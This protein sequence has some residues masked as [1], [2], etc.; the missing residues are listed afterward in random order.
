MLGQQENNLGMAD[1]FR[2]LLVE[3]PKTPAAAQAHYWIGWSAFEAKNYK[4]AI[5]S[6]EQ[7]RKL[8]AAQYGE[9]ASLRIL[10]SH[11]YLEDKQ[12]AIAEVENYFTQN[13]A[14]KIPGE[15]LRWLG[16][17]QYNEKNFDAAERY[18]SEL[19][20]KDR[21]QTADAETWYY[22]AKT[23]IEAGNHDNALSA[24]QQ[25]VSMSKEDPRARARGLLAVAEAH[26]GKGESAKARENAEAAIQLQ[27]EGRLNAEGRI[28]LGEVDMKESKFQDAAKAFLSVAVLYNDPTLTPLALDRARAAYRSAGDKAQEDKVFNELRTKFPEYKPQ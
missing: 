23:R 26:L 7:A 10:L 8:D 16:V 25:F 6:L 11:Y 24:A 27:P 13:N 5:A 19:T 3:Y 4:E 9:R 14:S 1:T 18:L 17:S 12:G 22:L 21:P 2:Q 28:L 20:S 15:V